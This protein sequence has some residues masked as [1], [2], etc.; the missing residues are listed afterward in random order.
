MLLVK[1]NP[2]YKKYFRASNSFFFTTYIP[3]EKDN[4]N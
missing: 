4:G 2:I 3:I 1:S